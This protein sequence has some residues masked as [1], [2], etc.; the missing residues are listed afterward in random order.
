MIP[1]NMKVDPGKP[2]SSYFT[3]HLSV[4]ACPLPTLIIYV[5]E[6]AVS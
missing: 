6:W 5:S 3:K 1:A 4:S 2:S